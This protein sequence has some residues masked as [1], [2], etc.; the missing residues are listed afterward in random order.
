MLYNLLVYLIDLAP[1]GVP[2]IWLLYPCDMPQ[3]LLAPSL[4]L[5]LFS[6]PGIIRH[7]RLILSLPHLN[8]FSEKPISS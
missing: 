5:S 1:V 7:S 6:I 4:S 8:H 2:L 3:S